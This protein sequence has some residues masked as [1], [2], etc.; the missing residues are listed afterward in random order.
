MSDENSSDHDLLLELKGD[1]KALIADVKEIKDNTKSTLTDH[2]TRIRGLEKQNQSFF[3][4][5]KAI[6]ISIG[7]GV[8]F[9]TAI[10]TYL[11]TKH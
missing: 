6:H 3:G 11:L 8:A 4:G 2:E 9:A 1:V 7:F 5:L 10:F